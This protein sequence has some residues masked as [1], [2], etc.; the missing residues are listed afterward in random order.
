[1][2][3]IRDLRTRQINNL[4]QAIAAL[5]AQLVAV[6]NE[7]RVQQTENQEMRSQLEALKTENEL[8]K[9]E[10]RQHKIEVV[11]QIK[12]INITTW[13]ENR[14]REFPMSPQLEI[15]G[16]NVEKKLAQ[17]K[18]VVNAVISVHGEYNGET[19]YDWS[20]AGTSVLAQGEGYSNNSG[21]HRAVPSL[22]VLAGCEQTGVHRLSLN[23]RMGNGATGRPFVQINPAPNRHAQMRQGCTFVTVT[24]VIE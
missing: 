15:L 18:L 16:F 10:L 17:S 11:S 20:Y 1:M 19:T 2:C 6:A 21:H 13:F 8:L 12:V 7:V 22:V 4:N 23:W 14:E 3:H 24:E 9:N 5:A